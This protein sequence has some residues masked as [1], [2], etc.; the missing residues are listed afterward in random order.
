MMD[1]IMNYTTGDGKTGGEFV[2]FKRGGIGQ[3]SFLKL[4]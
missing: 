4:I 3:S 2:S 1:S